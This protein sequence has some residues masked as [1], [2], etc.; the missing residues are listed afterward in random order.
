MPGHTPDQP[1]P[2]PSPPPLPQLSDLTELGGMAAGMHEVYA[3][4]QDA[5]FSEDRA[6]QLLLAMVFHT[7]GDSP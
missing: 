2:Q 1:G 6:F 3:S 4:L 7:L 5:G